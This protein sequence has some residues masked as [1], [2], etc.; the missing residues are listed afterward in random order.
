MR[1]MPS[2]PRSEGSSVSQFSSGVPGTGSTLRFPSK[3]HY[4]VYVAKQIGVDGLG[5][6]V[7]D[8]DADLGE[9]LRRKRR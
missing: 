3:G 8:V 4:D 5:R 9:R 7:A 1:S 2:M 6:L